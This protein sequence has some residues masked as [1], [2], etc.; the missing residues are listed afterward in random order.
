M[1]DL[2]YPPRVFLYHLGKAPK[3]NKIDSERERLENF[4]D[5]KYHNSYKKCIN[6]YVKAIEAG[7]NHYTISSQGDFSLDLLK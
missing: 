2:I 1:Q 6:I 4:E 7:L 5:H 3:K